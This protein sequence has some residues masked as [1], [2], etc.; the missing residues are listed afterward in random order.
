MSPELFSSLEDAVEDLFHSKIRSA[1][2]VPGGDINQA[3]RL[4]LDGRSAFVKTNRSQNL[5]FFEAEAEGLAAIAGTDSIRVPEVFAKGTDR[6]YGSFLMMEWCEGRKE[7]ASTGNSEEILQ[8][9]TG[10]IRPAS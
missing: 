8:P 5:S 6:Q 7:K 4:D 3:F 9:C 10:R 2:C 1:V